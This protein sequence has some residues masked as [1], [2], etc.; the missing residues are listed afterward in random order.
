MHIRRSCLLSIGGLFVGLLLAA[1]GST[2]TPLPAAPTPSAVPP[3]TQPCPELAAC[4][5]VPTPQPSVD[6]PYEEDWITSGHADASAEPFVHWNEDDPAVVP[7]GCARC[8]SSYGYQDFLGADGSAAG[9]VDQPAAIGSVINCVACHNTATLTLTSVTFPSGLEVTGLGDEARCMQCHQGRASKATVDA[10]IESAGLTDMDTVSDDLGFT[11][12]HYFAAAATRYGTWAMGGYEYEGQPY[13]VKF[14]HVEGM[15]TCIDCHDPHTLEVQVERCADCHEGVT[16]VEDLKDVRWMGSKVDYDG[17]GDL[18]EGIYYEIE[19]LRSMLYEAMRTYSQEITG[20]PIAYSADT[21]PYFLVDLNGNGVV[22]A[23]EASRDNGFT[24]WTG[25]LAKAAYNLHTSVKDPGAFAHGGKYVIELL[26]DSIRDLNAALSS[27][28]DLTAAHRVD[29]GHFDSSAEPFRHWDSAGEVQASCAKCHSATGLPTY[30][31]EGVNVSAE[32]SSGFACTTCHEV[33]PEGLVP[34]TVSTVRFPSGVSLDSGSPSSNVCIVCHQGRESAAS[35]ERAVTGFADDE[36]MPDQGFIN[37]HYLAAGATLLGGNAR[38]MYQYPDQA[39]AGQLEHVQGAQ[40][41]VDCHDPHGLAADTGLCRTCH[42]T[43]DVSTIRM[44]SVDYD[45]DRNTQEGL[46]QEVSTMEDLVYAGMLDYAAT[47]LE[48]PIVYSNGYP[49]FL[50]DLNGNGV[51][52]ADEVAGSNAYAS[53]TPRLLKAAY[54]Y[55]YVQKEPGA[56]AH[57]GQYVLQVLYDTVVDL[58]DQVTIDTTVMTRP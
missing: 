12:I 25:R 47:V 38:G 44:S 11:N 30:L 42:K 26:Y 46:A 54:N 52:D 13:D 40:T 55:H 4:P 20:T 15:D 41:C 56:F 34:R 33:T 49:Y 3:T 14:A 1:C 18:Q 28:V 27:P 58:G 22:D 48:A 16:T 17:D 37:V 5:E 8:H 21:Y 6:I 31:A 32:I 9:V 39:Y 7:E 51:A 53:W 19:G 50:N 23:D 45:G 24:A 29:A 10:S 57:N 35:V 43:D 2:A 36:V